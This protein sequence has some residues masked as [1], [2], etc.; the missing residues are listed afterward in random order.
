MIKW[1]EQLAKPKDPEA[2][3]RPILAEPGPSS[4]IS[5]DDDSA[6]PLHHISNGSNTPSSSEGGPDAVI[7]GMTK[8]PVIENPQYFGITNSQLKPD[9]SPDVIWFLISSKIINIFVYFLSRLSSIV[10]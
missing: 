8:I 7:I 2:V 3:L 9:T 1:R 10:R 5:N 6:S 4:V